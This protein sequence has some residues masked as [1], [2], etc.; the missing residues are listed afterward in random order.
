MNDLAGGQGPSKSRSTGSKV[1]VG[2]GIGC[3]VLL[4]LGLIIG[5]VGG[6]FGYQK[7]KKVVDE[8]AGQ[9][10]SRGYERVVGQ[11]LDINDTITEPKVY[12]AQMVRLFGD[13]ETDIA[14]I[15][16]MAEVHGRVKGNIDFKGQMLTLQPSAVIE[17]N[18]AAEAQMVQVNRAVVLGE[19]TGQHQLVDNGMRRKLE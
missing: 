18:V 1:L 9:Y 17:G 6:Y 15:A 4:V 12:V 7:L 2:C 14:I 11:Q 16:Q 3:L 19:I 13:C 5:G 8:W 10:E